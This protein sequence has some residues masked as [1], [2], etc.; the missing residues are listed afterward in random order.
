[1]DL[2]SFYASAKI[3]ISHRPSGHKS[4]KEGNLSSSKWKKSSATFAK[5]VV[6]EE[7]KLR[8]K[9]SA[10]LKC[11]INAIYCEIRATCSLVR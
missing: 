11:E 1:M 8:T 7:L 10:A 3:L 6:V 5:D 9:E 4:T 2:F